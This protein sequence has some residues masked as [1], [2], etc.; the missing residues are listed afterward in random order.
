MLGGL[1]VRLSVCLSVRLSVCVCARACV[2]VCVCVCA[3][4]CVR[5]CGDQGVGVP[6]S[7]HLGSDGVAGAGQVL[8][9]LSPGVGVGLEG[10]VAPEVRVGVQLR[11]GLRFI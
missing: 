1:S 2:C 11:I 3:R 10:A 6:L 4:V 9:E 7:R 5:V 8:S